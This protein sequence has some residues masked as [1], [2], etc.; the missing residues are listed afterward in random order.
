MG[1]KKHSLTDRIKYFILSSTGCW[2]CCSHKP[3]PDGYARI[4]HSGKSI[5]VHRLSYILRHGNIPDGAII[6]HSC[7]NRMCINPDHLLCGTQRDNI[8]DRV[9]RHRSAI[10]SGH[11]R[12]KLDEHKVREIRK[13]T[14]STY[15]LAKKYGVDHKA[16]HRARVG[17]TWKHVA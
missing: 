1:I 2:I 5:L 6:R 11:G 12:A 7:D 16:V 14:L 8:Q 3:Y 9:D 10:G 15:D 13:S 17:E 4:F